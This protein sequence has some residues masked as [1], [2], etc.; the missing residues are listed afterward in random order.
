[1]IKR[2]DASVQSVIDSKY[3]A[4]LDS[5]IASLSTSH[6]HTIVTLCISTDPCVA[7]W[8]HEEPLAKTL[9]TVLKGRIAAFIA[10]ERV[11]GHVFS[12][13]RLDATLDM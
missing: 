6:L 12:H 5:A 11:L 13:R 3:S 8:Q 10:C 9:R 4:S 1:M 2:H 7:T